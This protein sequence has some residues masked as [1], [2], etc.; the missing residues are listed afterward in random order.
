MLIDPVATYGNARADRLALVDLASDRRWSW[1]EFDRAAN[2]V[3]HMLIAALGARSGA[4]V[5]VLAK[6][7]ACHILLQFGCVRAGA[8]FV[9]INWRL[10]SAEVSVIFR[11]ADPVLLF[12]DADMDVGE[13]N[14]PRFDLA[15]LDAITAHHDAAPPP[16]AAR[17]DFEAPSTLLYTSG[18]SGQPKG[19]MI[20][21]SNAYWGSTNF[22]HGN[23]VS[24]DSVFLCDL[25]LFHTAGLFGSTRSPI[26]AGA[27]V[28]ISQGFD[29]AKTLKLFASPELAISHYFSVPQMAQMLWNHADFDAAAFACLKV[30]STGG[31]PNPAALIERFVRAGIP[32]SNGFGMTETGSNA[33]MPVDNAERL[34]AKG[35][36]CGIP[37]IALE[38]RI[39]DESGGEVSRGETGELLLRGPSVTKGYWN[40]PE[41]T[42]EA[43]VDGWFRTGD[44]A[45]QD[46]D[47][48][49]YL[50]DRK[51]DMFISGGENVYPA[52]VEAAIAEIADIAECAVIGVPDPQWGE[53][54]WAY[55]IARDGVAIDPDDVV[56]HCKSRL[57]AY[58]VPKKIIS[59]TT[60]PRTASGKVQKHL[61]KSMALGG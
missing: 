21:E 54:G 24:A 4:R 55:V 33:G 60:L 47:G 30:Y 7:S 51:K 49:F 8:I 2:R 3:A 18:T 37:Y 13:F 61:L 14:G 22:I 9:P 56:V 59:V 42:A 52:E 16:Y 43:F 26:L 38:T 39:V 10:A 15:T 53:V 6:N 31:A 36:S 28:L 23:D 46:A 5:A 40:Q 32:M 35:G 17:Q 50:V 25:P 41:K 45:R 48:Y 20:S 27:T 44:A 29:P 1:A 19:V 58:K 34:I 12:R 11:D 57:A